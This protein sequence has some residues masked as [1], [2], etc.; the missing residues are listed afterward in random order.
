MYMQREKHS[1]SENPDIQTKHRT[2][3]TDDTPAVR[4]G[5]LCA[6]EWLAM[7]CG[8]VNRNLR[9]PNEA[10]LDRSLPIHDS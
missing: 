2:H 3:V 10:N 6:F 8:A 5:K 1:G 4:A 7:Q 9:L